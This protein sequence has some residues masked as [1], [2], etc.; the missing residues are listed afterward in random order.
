MARVPLLEKDQADPMVKELFQKI[1]DNG[2]QIIK[3][4]KAV[5]NSPYVVRDFVRMGNA[6]FRRTELPPKLRELAILRVANLSG[7]EYERRQ[8]VPIAKLV[9]ISQEQIDAMEDWAS[10][11][12]FNEVERAA[13]QYTDEVAQN[14]AAKDGTF[15]TLR[16][17]LNNREIVELTL[18]IGYWGMLARV[19][20]ALE[21]DMDEQTASTL[22]DL[23]GRRKE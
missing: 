18:S 23:Q 7:C 21:I 8:H 19:L 16:N 2:A 9:G 3:L 11:S 17:H 13:L 14:V 6:L 5:A 15:S 22:D 1:E 12:S 4:Y 20:V 10:S